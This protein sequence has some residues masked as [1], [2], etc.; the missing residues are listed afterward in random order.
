MDDSLD[1]FP[2]DSV[3]A[4]NASGVQLLARMGKENLRIVQGANTPISYE[5]FLNKQMEVAFAVET[6]DGPKMVFENLLE[7]SDDHRII[8]MLGPPLRPGSMRMMVYSIPQFLE[9]PTPVEKPE[10]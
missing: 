3:L 5:R 8:L 1:A 9:P 2:Q 4:F 6:E 10:S 7:F